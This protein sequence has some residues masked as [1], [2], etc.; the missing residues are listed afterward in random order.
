VLM[1]VPTRVVMVEEVEAG[2]VLQELEVEEQE[3]TMEDP[4]T[5]GGENFNTWEHLRVCIQLCYI[6][7]LVFSVEAA[8]LPYSSQ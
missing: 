6:E 1:E 7:L 5:T 2:V 4:L 3:E 8:R